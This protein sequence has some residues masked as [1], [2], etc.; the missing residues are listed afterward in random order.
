MIRQVVLQ[1]AALLLLSGAFV[2]GGCCTLKEHHHR[3]LGPDNSRLSYSEDT[4]LSKAFNR[5]VLRFGSADGTPAVLLLHEV[6]GATPETLELGERL[7]TEGYTVYVPVLFGKVGERKPNLLARCRSRDFHCL[8]S[9]ASPVAHELLDKLLPRLAARHSVIGVIGMC[10]TGNFPLLLFQHESVKAAVVSQPALPLFRK[11]AIGLSSKELNATRA[12]LNSRQ[13]RVLYF[14]YS[15]DCL[16]PGERLDA[17]SKALPGRVDRRVFPA[18]DSE[19]HAVLTD[20]L[21]ETPEAWK[22]LTAYLAENL[23][24]KAPLRAPA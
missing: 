23:Q 11:N 3:R 4:D 14:R 6:G 1:P 13:A 5:K 7:R 24:G 20:S 10:L 19:H 17:L 12:A 16:S 21:T 22:C 18:C 8:S 2:S 9:S 15:L